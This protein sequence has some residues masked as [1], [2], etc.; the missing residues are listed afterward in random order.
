[1]GRREGKAII[2]RKSLIF[3]RMCVGVWRAADERRKFDDKK[4]MDGKYNNDGGGKR[5]KN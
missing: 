5:V 4:L 1:M 3:P 2:M